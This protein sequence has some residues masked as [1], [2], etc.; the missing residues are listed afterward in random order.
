MYCGSLVHSR[1]IYPFGKLLEIWYISPVLVYCIM[2][3][4]ASRLCARLGVRLL[5]R[6]E[7]YLLQAK[8]FSFFPQ[9]VYTSNFLVSLHTL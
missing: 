6:S 4:L 7:S 2:K 8:V 5:S 9:I 1:Y 3:N